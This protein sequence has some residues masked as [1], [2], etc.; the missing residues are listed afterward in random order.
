MEE[1]NYKSEEKD[2][3][4]IRV[5]EKSEKKNTETIIRMTVGILGMFIM[6]IV[7]FY[8]FETVTGNLAYI[9]TTEII[10]NI[11]WSYVLYLTV[12]GI[13]GSTRITIPLVSIFLLALSMAESF[14]MEFRS[15]PIT[16]WDITAFGTAI[17]V[18]KNYSFA[19]SN[20]M[21]LSIGA[22][23]GADI[24]FIFYP[25]KLRGRKQRLG[26]F[27][28]CAA[29]VV[30]YSFMFFTYI[31]PSRNYEINIWDIS[32]T[33]E[34][35]GYLLTTALFEK[36]IV[37]S[38]PPGYSRSELASIIAPYTDE[39]E[40]ESGTDNR[41]NG[42]ASEDA[43]AAVGS[44]TE[45]VNIIC[46]MNESFSDLSV[47]GDFDTNTAYLPY[48]YSIDKNAIRGSLCVPVFG[49]MTANTEFE[50]L[51]GD[52]ISVLPYATCAYQFNVHPGEYSLV[53]TLKDQGYYAVAMHPY[54]RENWNR[55]NVYTFMDFDEF[56]DIDDYE[57]AEELRNYVSDKADFEKIIETVEAKNDP[58]DKLFVF[59]VTMQN[60]G[61]Y[62][63]A[64]DNFDQEVELTGELAGKYPEADRY[65]S[66]IKKS[67]DAFRYLTEYFAQS[68]EPTMIVMFGD[69]Q[70]GVE[71]E[72]Y[73]EIAGMSSDE[74]PIADRIMWYQT[75]FMIWTNYDMPYENVGKLSSLFLSSYVLKAAGL[76]MTPYNKLLLDLSQKVPVIHPNGCYDNEG[77]FYTHDESVMSSICPYYKEILNYKYLS[78]N[79][80]LD[81]KKFT[82]AFAL[83]VK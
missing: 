28:G 12:F 15:R 55:S 64:F 29:V 61:G 71:D 53:S 40:A 18:T 9:E 44:T 27:A 80:S 75:P 8:L 57:G 14:V 16:V 11:C 82:Q 30:G 5:S 62:D 41:E 2:S 31:M 3:E 36:Y 26:A 17:S 47:A 65:L 13:S 35:K 43:G 4:Q 22:V 7:S 67:D 51:T 56:Y 34:T 39:G 70:P 19:L 50:F 42:D 1:K 69:H 63:T 46:I 24:I 32:S 21:R 25:F 60:H 23:L 33:Y 54:P 66:L 48:W 68:D 81:Q 58:S 76:K 37:A 59:N 38:P 52:S 83:D 49:A 74:V 73:D 10:F 78:Y 72:F 20:A 77:N 6:P 79:H 45:P